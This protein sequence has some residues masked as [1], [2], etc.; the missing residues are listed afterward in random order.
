MTNNEDVQIPE[1]F[2]DAFAWIAEANAELDEEIALEQPALDKAAAQHAAKARSGELGAEWQRV[3]QR[4]DLNE[5]SL[6][7]VFSGEDETP[8]ARTLRERSQSNL[9]SLAAEWAESDE[10]GEDEPSPAAKLSGAAA[11]SL[12]HMQESMKQIEDA[13][14]RLGFAAPGEQ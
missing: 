1:L 9:R 3:Q 7:A 13:L 10:Q 4:I 2:R 8:A 14:Q 12:A 6:E 11:E 5:T